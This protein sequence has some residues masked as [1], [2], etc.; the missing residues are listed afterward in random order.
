MT[1][2]GSK[3]GQL[4]D[5]SFNMIF[6]IFL[7]II[8]IGAAGIA[9][10]TLIGNAEH[11]EIILFIQELNSE[12]EKAW[13]ATSSKKTMTFELPSKLEFVCFSDN[14]RNVNEKDFP[15]SRVYNSLRFYFEEY[16]D[17][18]VFFYDP[19]V[20]E[21]KDM[22]PYV[23]IKCGSSQRN[24]LSLDELKEFNEICCIENK[25]GIKLTLRKSIESPDTYL[26]P[27]NC[28]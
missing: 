4:F 2:R 7:I 3:R 12:I 21:G 28:V 10:R 22:T 25:K 26:V 6:S 8:F 15:N 11:A 23:A 18:S 27:D 19:A 24:C 16:G 5:M 20:L 9:A 1:K 13:M 14:L 17:A